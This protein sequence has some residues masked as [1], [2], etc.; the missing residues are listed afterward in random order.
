[1]TTS[2]SGFSDL[3]EQSFD[4]VAM[5]VMVG[6]LPILSASRLNIQTLEEAQSFLLSYGYD[7]DD[8][9]DQRL[10]F[11]IH[12]R[13]VTYVRAHLL[14]PSEEIPPEVGDPALL[15]DL[16]QLLLMA[17]SQGPR[18]S[19]Q[20]YACALLKVMH[21]ICHLNNDLFYYFS[22]E[23]QNQIFRPYLDHIVEEGDSVRLGNT[24]GSS[25]AL[26]RFE[27]KPFKDS[28]SAITKLIAKP[29]AT[30]FGVLDK[31]GVRFITKTLYDSFRVMQYLMD[32]GVINFAHIVSG[33]SKNNLYP[34]NLFF[35]L[36]EDLKSRKGGVSSSS[37]LNEE[38]KNRLREQMDRAQFVEKENQ[39][40]DQSY[41]FF[42]FIVRHRIQVRHQDRSFSFFY[43]NEVQ[44]LDQETHQAN[45]SGPASHVAYKKRQIE[46]A[47]RRLFG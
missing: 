24:P 15:T 18:N 39:F 9:N 25:F 41:R 7:Y 8:M 20:I 46:M 44:I 38:M 29:S 42:K 35:E 21:V 17:S 36:M 23:I 40:T 30:S 33:Q 3:W 22:N 16:R 4:Q 19:L 1:M 2:S 13:A 28:D 12:N 5:N 14:L 26:H 43:P 32:R 37:H 47:R 10:L 34:A 31:I 45:E 27:L 11:Q 6:G